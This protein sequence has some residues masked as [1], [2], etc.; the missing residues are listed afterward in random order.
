MTGVRG[1]A[2]ALLRAP[3]EARTWL[4]TGHVVLGL[5]MSVL[6]GVAVTVLAA[7]TAVLMVVPPLGMAAL[8][9]LLATVRVGSALQRS[10]FASF[11]S[12]RISVPLRSSGEGHWPQRT[13]ARAASTWRQVGY[14]LLAPVLAVSGSAVVVASW[15][16]GIALGTAPLH[17]WPREGLFGWQ[18][19]HPGTLAALTAV[20]LVAFFAAPWVARGA[21]A[22]EVA[23]ARRLLGPSRAENLA[24][25]VDSLA[26]SRAGTISAADAERRRI[27]RDLHDGAQ[28]RL[29]S[30]AMNL[31]MARTTLSDLP[32]E[33]R[34]VIAQAHDEAKQTLADLRDLV[35][36][37]HPAMLTDRGLDAALSGLAARAP[38]PVRIRVDVSRRPALAIEAVAYFVVSESL[39]NVAKHAQA[40]QATV[41]VERVGD[42]L[43]LVVT[44]DGCGGATTDG[45]TGLRG[46]A[47]R[48]ASVDGSLRIDSPPGGPTRIIAELPCES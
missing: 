23:V 42:R 24:R 47:Q 1:V 38:L 21:A 29:T 43:R 35:R 34:D 44:D 25:R 5:P 41:T 31:G 16:I 8:A 33:A 3:W 12:V 14:H 22:L 7:L 37:L 36:G 15:S 20:G 26:R 48:I 27:E 18:L 6:P 39:T 9:V 46:L 4:A 2:G 17:G 11:L 32:E 19:R 40:S 13:E 28:Q 30:L 45:G 10:R